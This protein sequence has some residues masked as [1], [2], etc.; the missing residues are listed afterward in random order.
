MFRGA[1]LE[2]S[3]F[4]VSWFTCSWFGCARPFGR[5]AAVSPPRSMSKSGA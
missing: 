5:D 2:N 4:L 3:G 1:L